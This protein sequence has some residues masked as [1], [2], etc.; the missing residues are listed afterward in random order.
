M[1]KRDRA[2][3]DHEEKADDVVMI[4]APS[5]TDPP[6]SKRAR[7][8]TDSD[9]EERGSLADSLERCGVTGAMRALL[10]QR[11]GSVKASGQA[12]PFAGNTTREVLLAVFVDAMAGVPPTSNYLSEYLK[13]YAGA[14]EEESASSSSSSS[15]PDAQEVWRRLTRGDIPDSE[16]F[17]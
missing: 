16:A 4:V 3:E 2:A 13:R 8:V 17:I 11:Y 6:T 7:I 12:T 15:L 5:E 9:P 1:S 10:L 14:V